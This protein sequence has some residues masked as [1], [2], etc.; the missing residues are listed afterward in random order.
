MPKNFEIVMGAFT[1]KGEELVM[2]PKSARQ[3]NCDLEELKNNFLEIS[4]KPYNSEFEK[5]KMIEN[6]KKASVRNQ[7]MR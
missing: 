3:M 6:A 5:K 1:Q 2:P 7:E 4:A